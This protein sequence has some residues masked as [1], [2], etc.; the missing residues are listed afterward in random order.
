MALI[1]KK[2]YLLFCV[3]I[4]F[5]AKAFGCSCKKHGIKKAYN[6][7]DLIFKGRVV[8]IKTLMKSDTL[9]WKSE[10]ENYIEKYKRVEFKF[11]ITEL[12]K[13]QLESNNVI[14]V[15]TGD[16]ANCGIFFEM[17]SE[18]LVYSFKSDRPVYDIWGN[19]K[20]LVKE[21]Q[22]TSYCTRTKNLELLKNRELR[23]LKALSRR[24]N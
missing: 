8:G 3:L 20:N 15:T 1:L 2:Q 5:S 11:E 17:N 14:I 12:I 13:G 24:K 4:L 9:Y 7:S 19:S 18:H 22:T 21:Y 6:Y 10:T 16:S 23:K